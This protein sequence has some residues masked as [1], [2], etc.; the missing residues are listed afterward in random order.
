MNKTINV[1][2]PQ[3]LTNLAKQ[4]VEA[5]YYSSVSEVIRDALRKMFIETKTPTINLSDK[6]EKQ[7]IKAEKDYKTGNVTKFNTVSELVES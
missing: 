1:S 5:G 3:G 4:Q 7:F 2:L 6:A